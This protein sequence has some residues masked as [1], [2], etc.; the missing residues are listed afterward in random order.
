MITNA[1]NVNATNVNTTATN[2]TATTRSA[3]F[4]QRVNEAAVAGAQSIL[5]FAGKLTCDG[6]LKMSID[7]K[8]T[9]KASEDEKGVRDNGERTSES[10]AVADVTVDAHA[11]IDGGIAATADGDC[12]GERY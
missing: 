3:G 9:V 8:L 6:Q 7:I 2:T 1:N 12:H 4:Q 5:G 10:H 11:D